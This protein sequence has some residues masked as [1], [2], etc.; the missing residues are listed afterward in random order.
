MYPDDRVQNKRW[1]DKMEK[2]SHFTWGKYRVIFSNTLLKYVNIN[3]SYLRVI[4]N[5]I[6]AIVLTIHIKSHY[7]IHNLCL[8]VPK[9]FILL[10]N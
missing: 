9:Q 1:I 2:F 3:Y 7:V 5:I 10:Y 8:K 6:Y 4:F